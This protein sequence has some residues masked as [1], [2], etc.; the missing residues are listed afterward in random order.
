MDNQLLQ[1][2]AHNEDQEASLRPKYL[3]EFIGQDHIKEN[4]GKFIRTVRAA[5]PSPIMISST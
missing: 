1:A 5:G 2:Q 4:L 3:D